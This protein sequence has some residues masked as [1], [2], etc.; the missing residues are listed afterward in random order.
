[1][2]TST[3]FDY[4]YPCILTSTSSLLPQLGYMESSLVRHEPIFQLSV[5]PHPSIEPWRV[6]SK[7]KEL[8]A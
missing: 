7:M 6:D 2:D 3:R 4:H 1:M 5:A 8:P